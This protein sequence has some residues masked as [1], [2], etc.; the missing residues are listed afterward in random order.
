MKELNFW[1]KLVNHKRTVTLDN[2]IHDI[3]HNIDN[4]IVRVISLTPSPNG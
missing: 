3:P 4:L 2:D 1:A